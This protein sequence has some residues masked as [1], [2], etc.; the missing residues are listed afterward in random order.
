MKE[1]EYNFKK[2]DAK[3]QKY[4]ADNNLFEFTNSKKKKKYI[5][6]MFPYPSAA[7]LHIG[8][9]ESYT[10]TDILARYYRHQG[11]NVLHP[12]GWDAFGLPTENFALKT[13]E[14]PQD[15][16]KKN[17]DNFRKQ[18]NSLGYSYNWNNEIDTTNPQYYKWT[19]WIFLQ[20]YK[21]GLAYQDT[22]PINWCPSCL[23]GLANEEVVGGKCDRC[24]TEVEK[25]DMQQWLLKITDYAERLL[26]GLVNLDWP[27]KIKALQR[28]WIGK[29]EGAEIV[30]KLKDIEEELKVFTTRP[31][32]LYGVTYMAL[33]PEHRI[34]EEY[35][36]KIKNYKEIKEYLKKVKNKSE[37][38]RTDLAKEKTGVLINGLKGVNPVNGEELP[39]FVADYVLDSYGSGVVMAVP[40][41]DQRDWEFAQKFNLNIKQ[42]VKTEGNIKEK[43]L[44]GFGLAINSDKFDGL[45][46]AEFKKKIIE[47][48]VKDNLA[49]KKVNY[50][51]RDWVFSRQRYWGEPIPIVHCIKCGVVAVAEKDLPVELP[52]IDNY[53]PTGNGESPLAKIEEWVNTECPK[54]HGKAK[55]ETNTMPQWAGSSWYFLRYIDSQNDKELANNN[56][57]KENLP[58]DIYIGGA[59]HA[60]LH[61]LY[62]RFWQMFLYDL[63]VVPV[64]EPFLKLFNQ[65][66][67]LAEDGKKMSKSKGNVVNP[68][69]IIKQYGADVLRLYIMF[70]GPLAD[71][72]PW[73]TKSIKGVVNFLK[74]IF[75]LI[76][77]VKENVDS[78][79][80]N[81]LINKTIKKV[82]EDIEN[83]RFNTAIS[84][85]MIFINEVD[86]DNLN[87]EVFIKLLILLSPFA[88]HL[89][90][91]LHSNLNYSESL[92]FKEWPQYNKELIKEDKVKLAIQ[93]NGKVRDFITLEIDKEE[94]KELRSE[95]LSLANIKKHIAQKK[96]K[97]FIYIKNKIISIVI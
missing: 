63:K 47:Y 35:Q 59:E 3:W 43:A 4:W 18:I 86:K 45:E 72:K 48:L 54:C 61:L 79:E 2:I 84:S 26:G 14:H 57:L 36:D 46:T 7:G 34:I 60:V 38:E 94:S 16:T 88:P 76:D 49:Q 50:K 91:E 31:D 69:D 39:I 9:T 29:S 67:I 40:A 27:E 17:I 78:E 37:L 8:H 25:K 53:Q 10:A 93:V 11:F 65:G 6:D 96:I 32:T 12:M 66:M 71:E 68:D 20:L 15:I 30:F 97:K 81:I 80:N 87:K 21:K 75:L 73:N 24:E 1:K 44:E 42:V 52:K 13:G 51:L 92:M 77:S 56:L 89:T 64:E 28:N 23:T 83:I 82:T 70:M 58:V 74:K 41:H 62:A 55:R 5:L 33:A 85:L 95:V 22:I 19:Q 90:E